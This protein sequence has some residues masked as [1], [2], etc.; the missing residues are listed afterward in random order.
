MAFVTLLPGQGKAV[1]EI[2]IEFVVKLPLGLGH[3]ERLGVYP[4]SREQ[5]RAI[6]TACISLGAAEDYGVQTMAVLHHV[7]GAA[8]SIV[9]PRPTSSAIR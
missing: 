7:D 9:L 5:R 6:G 8:D 4:A 3:Y 1:H 2:D